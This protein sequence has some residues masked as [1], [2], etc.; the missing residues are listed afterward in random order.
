MTLRCYRANETKGASIDVINIV[1]IQTK[2]RDPMVVAAASQRLGLPAPVTG[3]AEVY[4]RPQ[5]SAQ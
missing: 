2:L 3:T 1:T 4:G 5:A